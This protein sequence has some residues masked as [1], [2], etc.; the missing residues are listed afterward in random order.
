MLLNWVT[1]WMYC[2]VFKEKKKKNAETTPPAGSRKWIAFILLLQ[3]ASLIPMFVFSFSISWIYFYNFI[4]FFFFFITF[5]LFF[6]FAF[7]V[8]RPHDLSPL[9][10]STSKLE[11]F[12]FFFLLASAVIETYL[13]FLSLNQAHRQRVAFKLVGPLVRICALK[14]VH[15]NFHRVRRG[16]RLSGGRWRRACIFKNHFE[17]FI[18]AV[19]IIWPQSLLAIKKYYISCER[20]R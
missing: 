2:F 13:Q 11:I 1:G 19:I 8:S 5:Y 17:K 15:I 10:R 14:L 6:R 12:P 20:C 7:F 4:G 16:K 9:F 3:L 18:S